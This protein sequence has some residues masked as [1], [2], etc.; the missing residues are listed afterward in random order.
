[1]KVL[2]IPAGSSANIKMAYTPEFIAVGGIGSGFGQIGRIT[3]TREGTGTLLNLDDK[4]VISLGQSNSYTPADK[5]TLYIL[6][7]ADG[8]VNGGFYLECSNIGT[9]PIDV[10]AWSTQKGNCFVSSLIDTAVQNTSTRY[11]RFLKLVA[12][13]STTA[14]GDIITHF[15]RKDASKQAVL[16]TYEEVYAISSTNFNNQNLVTGNINENIVWDNTEQEYTAVVIQ[17]Q[18]AVTMYLQRLVK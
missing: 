9:Q 2:T 12:D 4:G 14:P 18:N 1:M 7:M 15:Y 10:Y 17:P 16:V 11:E 6:P 13:A 3:G 5:P 8:Y